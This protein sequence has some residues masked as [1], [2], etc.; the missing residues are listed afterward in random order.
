MYCLWHHHPHASW[1][2]GPDLFQGKP[3][4][5][6]FLTCNH[7]IIIMA[8]FCEWESEPCESVCQ[9]GR[10]LCCNCGHVGGKVLHWSTDLQTHRQ[11]SILRWL[12]YYTSTWNCYITCWSCH[13]SP[14][15]RFLVTITSTRWM[16]GSCWTPGGCVSIG[17]WV[18]S[19]SWARWA[20]PGWSQ[21]WPSGLCLFLWFCA[22]LWPK[23]DQK[24]GIN[25]SQ[26]IILF[27][28]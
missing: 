5:M 18:V 17:Q 4:G 13:H 3:H 27:A 9:S 16:A 11:S 23:R 14:V 25:S 22:A 21:S 15:S 24:R 12:P 2:Q 7:I 8:V 1:S 6:I 19:P 20:I 26:Q 10:D 28:I